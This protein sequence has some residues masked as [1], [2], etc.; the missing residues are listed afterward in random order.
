MDFEDEHPDVVEWFDNFILDDDQLGSL[1][2]EIE[3]A[4][5]ELVCAKK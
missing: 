2:S 5:S 3:T 4:D 1:M